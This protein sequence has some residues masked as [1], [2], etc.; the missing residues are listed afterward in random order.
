MDALA[1]DPITATFGAHGRGEGPSHATL[2]VS[3][4]ALR[5]IPE[6]LR[7]WDGFELDA[8]CLCDYPGT[9][10]PRELLAGAAELSW[11]ERRCELD[12]AGVILTHG[13]LHGLAA[14][15]SMLPPGSPVLFPQPAFGYPFVIAA[16]RCTPVPISWPPGSSISALLDAVAL[17]LEHTSAPSAV[18]ACFPSNPSGADP[19]GSEWRRL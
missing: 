15:L 12:P 9:Q 11:R 14:A 18:I 10:G 13:A 3:L 16:A 8:G 19:S 2:D 6:L 1:T 4:G 5:G 7:L 17:E